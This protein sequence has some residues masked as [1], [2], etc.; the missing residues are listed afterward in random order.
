VDVAA[1]CAAQKIEIMS[2]LI[3][4]HS[5]WKR[6]KQSA[7]GGDKKSLCANLHK[8]SDNV[9]PLHVKKQVAVGVSPRTAQD[10]LTIRKASPD[11]WQEVLDGKASISG[12]A[13]E[14]RGRQAEETIKS[15]VITLPQWKELSE[16]ER[17]EALAT[18]GGKTLNR[19]NTESIGWAKWSWNPITGCLHNCPYCYARDI[20]K[21]FYEHGFEPALIP[22]R[23]TAPQNQKARQS[24]DPAERN[25]FTGS[26][27]DIFGK[28][29]PEEWIE[30]VMASVKRSPEFNFLFLTKFP[31]RMVDRQVPENVW[32]GTSVDSQARVKAVEDAFAKVPA[33]TRWLS[34]E[35]LIEPLTFSRPELFQWVVIGGASASSQTP[36]WQP[37]FGWVADLYKR[38][39]EAGA[40][41][42]LKDN[43]GFDGP[44][45]PRDFPW[46]ECEPE[47]A[48]AAFSR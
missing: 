33:H 25:I 28:W 45:R 16:A 6:E 29:V 17:E 32:L 43:V 4:V 1:S 13:K 37:P 44:R 39:T 10:A 2:D 40:R 7:A 15:R 27:S 9:V 34:I 47:A 31:L 24:D 19:Q 5:Q 41:V 3:E 8:R 11:D 30:A 46:T 35:P 36:S 48:P 21:R 26:M 14:L 20:A 23:L 22:D 18:D 38:F 12:K 42:Y